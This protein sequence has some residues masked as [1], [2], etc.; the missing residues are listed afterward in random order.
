MTS[1]RE[2]L[3]L[4]PYRTAHFSHHLQQVMDGFM[5][6]NRV[7]CRYDIIKIESLH[8]FDG[9]PGYSPGQGS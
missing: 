5:R 1:R 9:V 8:T 4:M 3:E 7:D 6:I 2:L